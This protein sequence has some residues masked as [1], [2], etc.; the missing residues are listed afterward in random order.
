MEVRSQFSVF[1]I[2][3]PGVLATVTGALAKA[4]VNIIALALMD[5]GEHGAL[6]IVCD[7][8][9]TVRSVL[10]KTH[11]RWTEAEVL[12]L[13]LHNRPGAFADVARKLADQ[14]VNITYAYCSSGAPGGQT[15]AVFRID[16]M[17]KAMKVLATKSERKESD[18]R[19]MPPP[20]KPGV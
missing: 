7:D 11:D 20:G 14:H 8:A 4:R 10:G 13:Q 12:V 16:D 5:S 15:T 9:D 19:K 1:L 2:N 3:K 17:K 18:T 6:R